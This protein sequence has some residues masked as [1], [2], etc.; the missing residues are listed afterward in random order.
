MLSGDWQIGSKV[1]FF[2]R[3]CELNV[4]FYVADCLSLQLLIPEHYNISGTKSTR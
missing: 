3:K 2:F 1:V 4:L